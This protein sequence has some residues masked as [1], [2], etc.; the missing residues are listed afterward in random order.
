MKTLFFILSTFPL[1]A[2]AQTQVFPTRLTLTEE[3]PSSYLNLKNAT[4]K[5]QKYKIE[6][7]QYQMTKNGLM[8]KA[9]TKNNPLVDTLKFSPKTVEVAPNEKQ[10]VRV[11]ATS[12]DDLTDGDYYIYLHFIPESAS[13]PT[14][15]PKSQFSLQA[16]IAVAIPIVVRHGTAKVEGKLSDLKSL[17]SKD[18]NLNV[19]FKLSN[20]TKYFLTGDLEVIGVT[21]KGET[22]LS[23]TI[24][25]TSYI[26][27]RAVTSAISSKDIT[28]KLNGEKLKKIKV[29]FASNENSGTSFE[30]AGESGIGT[31]NEK[32]KKASKRR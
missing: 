13:S 7:T 25:L 24:G 30:L 5:P 19:T 6:M 29:K 10:V 31:A 14:N 17:S 18:G 12:F 3:A 26:P 32:S 11:M 22:S 15:A 16:K 20:P 23:K 4:D 21:D 27:E 8:V 2:F 28:E 1:L 9:D